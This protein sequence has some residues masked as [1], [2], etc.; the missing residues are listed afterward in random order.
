MIVTTDMIMVARPCPG[1]SCERVRALVG[2]GLT[3]R[4]IA[5]LDVPVLDRL[6]V[7][8]YVVLDDRRRRLLACDCA[9]RALSRERAAGR[10]P[11][12]RSWTAVQM[13]RRY[14]RGEATHAE[15][16]AAMA[17]TKVAARDAA[18]DADDA[19]WAAA[20]AARAASADD[21]AGAAWGGA[22]AA[23]EAAALDAEDAAWAAWDAECDW[24]IAR[25][26]EYAEEKE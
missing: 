25:A 13:A 22:R 20:E 17:A 24:Q 8:S 19:A 11:D 14:A 23:A 12:E 6:W 21:V 10:E 2:D 15:L 5:G 18:L 16:D 1:Y 26:L 3:P 7:L 9:E 4:Q